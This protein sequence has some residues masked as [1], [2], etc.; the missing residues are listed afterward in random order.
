[1]LPLLSSSVTF[2]AIMPCQELLLF[3]YEQL[4]RSIAAVVAPNYLKMNSSRGG[5]LL[6]LCQD[7][8]KR[9][10]TTTQHYITRGSYKCI[11]TQ[12]L[13]HTVWCFK[14]VFSKFS[15]WTFK[16]TQYPNE[17]AVQGGW[18]ENS[19]HRTSLPKYSSWTFK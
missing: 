13:S 9:S 2:E 16:R 17:N 3:S 1:M 11:S 15:S 7:N 5:L 19:D 14:N 6:F 10:I 12:L 4:L 8:I 18:E